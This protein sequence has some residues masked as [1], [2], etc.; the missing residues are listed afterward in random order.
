ME[1]VTYSNALIP[2]I[3]TEFHIEHTL[4]YVYYDPNKTVLFTMKEYSDEVILFPK[5]WR[6]VKNIN[7]MYIYNQKNSLKSLQKRLRFYIF[8][9]ILPLSYKPPHYN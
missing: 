5:E 2:L 3:E 9:A 7:L 8:Q 6:D 1:D 4:L